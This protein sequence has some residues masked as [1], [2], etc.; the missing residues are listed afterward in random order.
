MLEWKSKVEAIL[1]SGVKKHFAEDRKTAE[2]AQRSSIA[3][4][5]ASLPFI[6]GC[7]KAEELAEKNIDTLFKE[8]KEPGSYAH[9]HGMSL[10]QRLAPFDFSGATNTAALE[11]GLLL[12]ELGSLLDHAR[13]RK[14]DLASKTPNP[15]NEGMEYGAEKERLLAAIEAVPSPEMDGIV[16][17]E[18]LLSGRDAMA[19]A[20]SLWF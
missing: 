2:H 1:Q 3:R 17:A 14:A 18:R 4:L 16:T 12:L 20:K 8:T 11:R 5:V 15:L 9:R 6:A 13:D 7:P 19:S 10:R